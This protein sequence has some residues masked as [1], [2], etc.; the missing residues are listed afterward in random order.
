MN[1]GIDEGLILKEK[2][3]IKKED[4]IYTVHNKVNKMFP[5]LL[6]SLLKEVFNKKESKKA[7]RKI[8]KILASKK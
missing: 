4:D 2:A 1:E 3:F 6:T 8:Y 5:N 7:D